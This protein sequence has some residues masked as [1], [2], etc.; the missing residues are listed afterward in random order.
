MY[1][2]LSSLTWVRLG[3]HVRMVGLTYGKRRPTIAWP[4][5]LPAEQ[6]QNG[7]I[8][9]QQ[10]S[11]AMA[12]CLWGSTEAY[13]CTVQGAQ[14]ALTCVGVP[15]RRKQAVAKCFR[16]EEILRWSE[17]GRSC[18]A[19]WVETLGLIGHGLCDDGRLSVLDRVIP[20]PDE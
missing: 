20:V 2:R 3:H 15:R 4:P 6:S 14:L 13:G 9:K 7:G 12:T 10:R 5:G 8:V 16:I 18:F 1:V 11:P 19:R 17:T